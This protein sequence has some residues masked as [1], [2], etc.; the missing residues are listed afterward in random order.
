MVV[1]FGTFR[2]RINSAG[3]KIE[4]SVVNDHREVAYFATERWTID[5]REINTTTDPKSLDALITAIEVAYSSPKTSAKLLHDDLTA[6]AHVLGPAGLI[7]G[8]RVVK[9]PSYARYQNGEYVSYR[10]GEI[11]I[12][13]TK[14]LDNNP[15]RIIEFSES[16][17]I[18][19]GG[20]E[21]GL[22]QPNVGLAV[23]QQT[24]TNLKCTATQSGRIV[25]LGGRGPIPAP[26][27]PSALM[28]PV[29]ERLETPRNVNGQFWG[30]PAT[31]T[32]QF[33]SPTRLS[34]APTS[35]L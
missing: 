31:Y 1:E 34:G 33:E 8:V 22:L 18:D 25:Y 16:I 2:H 13:A 27:W 35:I 3:I 6:T 30:F 12:E 7:G 29:R 9:P 17:E 10:T 23:V 28:R 11:I 14:V 20:P 24:R 21:S 4:R 19:G 15:L 32:Y 5:F 26:L